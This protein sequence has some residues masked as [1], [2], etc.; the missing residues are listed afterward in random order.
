MLGIDGGGV[1]GIVGQEGLPQWV[2][3]G[4]EP[5]PRLR[6]E[7]GEK[8]EYV[9]AERRDVPAGERLEQMGKTKAV[10]VAPRGVAIGKGK[11]LDDWLDEE[12]ED[13]NSEEEEGSTEDEESGSEEETEEESEDEGEKGRLVR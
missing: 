12:D 10:V 3:E 6:D 4:E 9:A 1:E 5:D 2:K 11:S 8:V 13:E 7:R